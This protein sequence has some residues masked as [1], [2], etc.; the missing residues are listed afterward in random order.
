MPVSWAP[1]MHGAIISRSVRTSH[2]SPMG[3]PTVN[4]L[5]SFIHPPGG[6]RSAILPVAGMRSVRPDR[7]A[8]PLPLGDP[9]DPR[10]VLPEPPD[11]TPA[12]DDQPGQHVDDPGPV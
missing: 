4:S 5:S 9:L 1:G 8:R 7:A 10:G 3:T 11:G 2:A 6:R 12:E